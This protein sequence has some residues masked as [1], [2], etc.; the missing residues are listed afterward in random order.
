MTFTTHDARKAELA[1]RFGT[2]LLAARRR[3]KIGKRTIAVQT[4]ISRNSLTEYE[5]GRI[6]PMFAS[7]CRIADALGD[8]LLMAVARETRTMPCSICAKPI[9]NDAAHN[10]RYC[11]EACK[12]VD[13]KK[14]KGVVPRHSSVRLERELAKYRPAV[15]RMCRECEPAGAC[16]TA[17]CALRIV[18]PLPLVLEREPEAQM[19]PGRWGSGSAL[20]GAPLAKRRRAS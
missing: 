11:S 16:R 19:L 12:D 7:A 1:R 5:R 9:L 2:A 10:R 14:R 8:E 20:N 15:E 18:S 3:R 6:L 4:G 13:R 17:D